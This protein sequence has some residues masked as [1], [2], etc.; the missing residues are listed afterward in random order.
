MS[1]M[2]RDLLDAKQLHCKKLHSNNSHYWN[3]IRTD[4]IKIIKQTLNQGVKV[5]CLSFHF[6]PV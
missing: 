1:L 4:G 3:M 6:T 2:E 5:V